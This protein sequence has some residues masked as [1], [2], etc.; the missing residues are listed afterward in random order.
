MRAQQQLSEVVTG[1][2]LVHAHPDDETITTG[3]TMARLAVAGVPVTLV[4][5]TRGEA[6]EVIGAELAH[7]EGDGDALA[8]HREGELRCA[9]AELGVRDH[10]FLGAQAGRRFRDS[11][12]VWGADGLAAIP[13]DVPADAFAVADVEDVAALLATV[14]DEVTP[15]HVV[16]YDA[17]GGYGHPDHIQAARVTAR[18]VAVARHRAELLEVV[19]P[20]SVDQAGLVDVAAAGLAHRS[21]A[22]ATPSM[23]VADAD[24]DFVSDGQDLEFVRRAKASALRAHGTQVIVSDDDRF[25]ALSNLIWQP[26]T[27]AEYFRRSRAAG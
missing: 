3:A 11:G 13:D 16:S 4:T 1:L 7:L 26:L 27:T 20:E 23:V 2:L 19:T 10:R 21:L 18:A 24:V 14:I 9:A 12:M 22:D 8:A 25:F 5:C 6:G 17:G 15:S